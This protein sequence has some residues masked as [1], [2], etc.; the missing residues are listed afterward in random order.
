MSPKLYLI[1]TL[2]LTI[3]CARYS[4]VADRILKKAEA[5]VEQYPDSALVLLDS[6]RDLLNP[7]DAGYYSY[8]LL[9]VQA[10]DKSYRN[11]TSDTLIFDV[12]NYYLKNKDLNKVALSSYYCGRVLLE[13]KKYEQAMAAFL[14]A[15][16]YSGQGR[17]DNLKGL[18]Q[19]SIGEVYYKQFLQNKAIT[20]FKQAI[21]YFHQA[22]NHKNEIITFNL[23]GNCFL[24]Q[25]KHDS[26]FIYYR[27]GLALADQQ[28]IAG[29]Q[30]GFRQNL[31]VAYRKIGNLRQAKVLFNEALAFPVDSLE[32]SR[33]YYNLSQVFNEEN[34]NDSARY[35]LNR[36][37][38]A[39]PVKKDVRLSSNI[40]KTWSEIEEKDKN[41][42]QALKLHKQYSTYLATILD[43]NK[44]SAVLE[45]QK[46]YDF[47]LIQNKNH[48]L[49]IERQRIFLTALLL[50]LSIFILYFFFYWLLM[51]RKRKLLEA[52]Q[53][54]YQLM[55]LARNFDEKEI[56]FRAVLLSHFN[57][58]KKTAL[59]EGYLKEDEKKKGGHL[60]RIFN[61]IVYGQEN[62]DW[63]LVY[64]AINNLQNGFFD[65]LREIFP[66][67]D[68]PEFRICCLAY[69]EFTNTEIGILLEYQTNTVKAKKSTIR[70]KIGIETSGNFHDFLD[71]KVK[72]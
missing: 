33:L 6:V 7:G 44:N 27:K 36:A 47:Q 10:K 40:Y 53:R 11:I 41:Y 21:E 35:Y 70:K 67:L 71:R 48:R 18:I 50:V 37:L 69:A 60:L 43:E 54:I 29:E 28:G 39:L 51:Q 62:L 31:G 25:G 20:R 63:D 61:E 55:E 16:N 64:Q 42:Q 49:Q 45:I 4:P 13:Q 52:E 56:S 22:K 32:Q 34:Q 57:V 15:E 26:A 17:D 23:T 30:A 1:C 5:L 19:S 58:L 68:E 65:R 2:L 8:L 46:K 9:Q 66:Q 38:N 12:K 72:N 24:I 14:D 59:L 3:S